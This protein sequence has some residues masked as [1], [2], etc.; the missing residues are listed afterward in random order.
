MALATTR[1][2]DRRAHEASLDL[3]AALGASRLAR[4]AWPARAARVS[5]VCCGWEV[6]VSE[7]A[8]GIPKAR[9]AVRHSPQ[10]VGAP[11]VKRLG[12]VSRPS[13]SAR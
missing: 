11:F 6:H 8:G 13:D 4:R 3:P 9:R 1:E 2:L 10:P 5:V 7:R 12:E